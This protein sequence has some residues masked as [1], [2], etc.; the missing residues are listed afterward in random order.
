MISEYY[1]AIKCIILKSDVNKY[2]CFCQNVLNYDSVK[3]FYVYRTWG[4][5]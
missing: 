2:L 1:E 3:H 4:M 5:S